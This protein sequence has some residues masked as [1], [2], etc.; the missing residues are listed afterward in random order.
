LHKRGQSTVEFALSSVVLLFLLFGLLDL[1]RA[2]YYSVRLQD[3][4][5]EGARIGAAYN[6][7]AG[8]YPGLNP[9]AIANAVDGVL[10]QG[11]LPASVVKN[12]TCPTTQNGNPD[13]NQPYK[14]SAYPPGPGVVWLY[15]CYA[16]QPGAQPPLTPT[17]G[18]VLNVA[19]LYRFGLLSPVFQ[20]F[21]PTGVP[22]A[23]DYQAEIQGG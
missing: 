12:A 3:A 7:Q 2:F 17:A 1:G 13:Y 14:D 21:G 23:G 5:R 22:M 9:T 11:G 10:V 4:A 6:V 16:D 8:M 15:I 18:N 19:V 20:Q